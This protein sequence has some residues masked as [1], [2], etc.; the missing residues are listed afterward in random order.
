MSPCE[1]AAARDWNPGKRVSLREQVSG[2]PSSRKLDSRPSLSKQLAPPGK[3]A[4]PPEA[5]RIHVQRR[6]PELSEEVE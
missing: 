3:P 2:Q 1:Q 4:Q 6:G 5:S